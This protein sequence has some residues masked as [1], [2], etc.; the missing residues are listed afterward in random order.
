MAKRLACPGGPKWNE[1]VN[2]PDIGLYEAMK[3]YMDHDG[4]VRSVDEVLESIRMA[5][6]GMRDSKIV[7]YK[8]KA[9]DPVVDNLDKIRKWESDKSISQDTLWNKI[10]QLGIPKDQLELLKDAKGEKIEDKL[11]SFMIDY[12][13]QIKVSDTNSSQYGPT[14][15]RVRMRLI[16]PGGINYTSY[17]I[18][19]P[20]IEPI[21]EGHATFSTK[22]GIGWFRVDD[23][24]SNEK[25]R[26][27]LEIQ[28]DL[29]Q[30]SKDL[31]KRDILV[32]TLTNVSNKRLLKLLNLENDGT[33]TKDE[34]EELKKLQT[35]N[36]EN[37]KTEN[38]FLKILDNDNRWLTFFVKSIIQDSAKKGYDKVVFPTGKT[39]AKIEKHTLEDKTE[40]IESRKD[41]IEENKKKIEEI[42]K[43]FEEFEK[44]ANPVFTKN[45]ISI[46]EFTPSE[47]AI[48]LTIEIKKLP[49]PG[50][51]PKSFS[52]K[53]T[54]KKRLF[55]NEKTF[56]IN[57]HRLVSGS[58][59]AE[60]LDKLGDWE[61]F[62]PETGEDYS[63]FDRTVEMGPSD[64][65]LFLL[66]LSDGTVVL[67]DNPLVKTKRSDKPA[68]DG[69]YYDVV[70]KDAPYYTGRFEK[71]LA[72]KITERFEAEYDDVSEQVYEGGENVESTVMRLD[73]E[74]E[75][76]QREIDGALSQVVQGGENVVSNYPKVFNF[77]EKTVR[78]IL[79]KQYGKQNVQQITDEYGNTW[80]EVSVDTARDL[81]EIE[82]YRPT[83]L[84]DQGRIETYERT[85]DYVAGSENDSNVIGRAAVTKLAE[86][87]SD[88]LGVSYGMITAEEA[89]EMTANADVRWTNEPAFFMDDKV[90]F[91]G[92]NLTLEMAFHE[93]SH[94]FVKGLI[95]RNKDLFDKLYSDLSSTPEGQAIQ[96]DVI[97][98]YPNLE[99][100]S[101]RFKEEVMV[102]SLEKHAAATYRNDAMSSGFMK[103]IKDIM[104][105]IKQFLR[106][107]FGKVDVAKLSTNTTLQDLAEM[108]AKGQRF[109][110]PT[111]KLTEKGLVDYQRYQIEEFQDLWT[112]LAEGEDGTTLTELATL[113][114]Q[115]TI[116]S[117]R[118]MKESNDYEG[119]FNVLKDELGINSFEE[120]KKNLS[121]YTDVM[122][123]RMSEIIDELQ[124]TENH[125]EALIN[126]F[127]RLSTTMP[128]IT[129]HLESLIKEPNDPKNLKKAFDYG[130]IL[131]YWETFIDA[132]N[133]RFDE[134]KLRTTAPLGK[135]VSAIGQE[136]KR[137]QQKVGILN[138]E[139]VKDVITGIMRPISDRAG[140]LFRSAIATYDR[141]GASQGTR[142]RAFIEYHG[143][144]ESEY[145]EFQGLKESGKTH[146]SRYEQL[147]DKSFQYGA[148]IT[149]EKVQMLLS[150]QIKD[151]G[152]MNSWFEGYLYNDDPLVGGFSLF[153]K[154][155]LDEVDAKTQMK[156]NDMGTELVPLLEKIGYNPNKVSW[157]GD[158]ILFKD[159]IATYDADKKIVQ[160]EVWTMLNPFKDYRWYQTE[161]EHNVRQA[162]SEWIRTNSESDKK[163][164]QDLVEQKIQH[165]LDY[166]NNEF[167]DEFYQ[168]RRDFTKNGTNKIAVEALSRRDLLFEELR[169]LQEQAQD[170]GELFNINEQLE[171]IWNKVRMLESIYDVNGKLKTN[172]IK[173]KEGVV[174][175][176]DLAVA[177]ALTEYKEKTRKFYRWEKIKGSF[178][179]AL[180]KFEMQLRNKGIK[181]DAYDLA[182][183]A[184]IEANTRVVIKPEFFQE[185]KRIL[186]EIKG[187]LN[188]DG[189]SKEVN[190]KINKL[191]SFIN[192]SL[193]GFR[194]DDGQPNGSTISEGRAKMIRDA[195]RE[196]D[197]LRKKVK[198][199]D[200]L[201][202][203]R[204]SKLWQEY[205]ELSSN[206]PTDYY[207]DQLNNWLGKI[208]S[209]EI[210][211][212]FGDY[213]LDKSQAQDLISSTEKYNK[214]LKQILVRE[215][216][217]A[218]WFENNHLKREKS[219]G[220][221]EMPTIYY[222]R[223]YLWNVTV[224]TDP[225]Y[226][227][228]HTILDSNGKEVET[229]NRVPKIRFYRRVVKDEYR[230]GYNPDTKQ[231]ELKVGEHIDN[232]GHWLPK[233]NG[234]DDRYI[235][236]DYFDLKDKDPDVFKV[237]ETIKKYHLESQE[238]VGNYAKLYY[239]LPRYEQERLEIIQGEKVRDKEKE[240]GI[241]QKTIKNIREFFSGTA[242]DS[243]E[244]Q[245]MNW[246][247][248]YI[249]AKVELMD[250]GSVKEYQAPVGGLYDLEIDRVSKNVLGSV[251]RYM[252]STEKARK[253]NEIHPVAQA[254][255]TMVQQSEK[256][257]NRGAEMFKN[258][259]RV[260]HTHNGQMAYKNQDL[261]RN[262]RQIVEGFIDREFHGVELSPNSAFSSQAWQNIANGMF[263][264]SSLGYFAFNI[265]SSIKNSYGQRIQNFMEGAAMMHYNL[266][267]LGVGRVWSYNMMR[268]LS[269]DIYSN[270]ARTKDVQLAEIFD[271]SG[272][273]VQKAR[274]QGMSRTFLT[275]LINNPSG[276][277]MNYRKWNE[278][279]AS[280][281]VLGA[282]LNATKV[283]YGDGTISLL[284][285]WE[286]VDGRIQLKKGI[287]PEWGITYDEEGNQKIGSKFIQRKNEIQAVLRNNAG[288]YD[289]F[290]QPFAG[291]Y[292]AYRAVAFLRKYF[293]NMAMDRLGTKI[294]KIDG[295][296]YSL[297]RTQ[298]G[299]G[300]TYEGYYWTFMR[301]MKEI[302]MTGGKK[303]AFMLPA[304][305]RA[306]IKTITD[307]VR[308]YIV[309]MLVSLLFGWDPQDEER[310]AKLRAKSGPL[311]LP[312]VEE[313][314]NPFNTSG[315]LSN[316][317]LNLALQIQSESQQF[318]PL[319][320]YGLNDYIK[321]AEEL[322]ASALFGP[323]ITT[324]GAL[325][326]DMV[327]LGIG[328]KY[329]YYQRTVG[330][331]E[332]QQEGGMKFINH[333]LKPIGITGTFAEPIYGLKSFESAEKGKY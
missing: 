50:Q 268:Q 164:W 251:I 68:K 220:P 9:I 215:D 234:K 153:V 143:L 195:E 189:S 186:E 296:I 43:N 210:K 84:L 289:R 136:I 271:I 184:W 292:M 89:R 300:A 303:F 72:K 117:L 213:V 317:A 97:A 57:F 304:E 267:D 35:S 107:M 235:N 256:G 121:K 270:E 297:G 308:G 148:E 14:D 310:F 166:M 96:A 221:D 32:N 243:A 259:I 103:F 203:R 179:N 119:M 83:S 263:Q 104:Y 214:V 63:Y 281:E 67:A 29:F 54:I 156:M 40:F 190:E 185:R 253:L 301:L 224:P 192:Q 329:A 1:L 261:M 108:L 319:P 321:M 155:A 76:L 7:S 230:T 129:K 188:K 161:M 324:A 42:N 202:S 138:G 90:Y 39:I 126:T 322:D 127:F 65:K 331:Y 200:K 285:A 69:K 137:G 93:F 128:K 6:E 276:I 109:S 279:Q 316:H 229:I 201:L 228:S 291:R 239:D 112:A 284:D 180:A 269:M 16:V 111:E 278:M 169:K 24:E 106:G 274:K 212:L 12:G 165:D 223:S 62:D 20:E 10:Q 22:N 59:Y 75:E 183:Q 204:L 288:A 258:I 139:G 257:G 226:Y 290:N 145:R 252:F 244:T 197:S 132:V 52:K 198:I 60:A 211:K 150:G 80:N 94:P 237:L 36:L 299:L 172:E 170:E 255:R 149:D 13:Y 11:V 105:K 2:H 64:P 208:K 167:I 178:D 122:Q 302:V 262:R 45:D 320:G 218:E 27:I 307:L 159:I 18:S 173:T 44:Y 95:S 277:S 81:S 323:T 56:S 152:V 174:V 254:F 78:D 113:G 86:N 8:L 282:M 23:S 260:N 328:N 33:L 92:E 142:D 17:E 77:Y 28:S 176:N 48:N 25:V 266:K 286:V 140:E 162:Y 73:I 209:K 249:V 47:T 330:P 38:S 5:E 98:L 31:K 46:S 51:D 34:R 248:E 19:I 182:R 3:D 187:I 171:T 123:R 318:I 151:V 280:N 332:W 272:S 246:S 71:V 100:N 311:P 177:E 326:S 26:R 79:N 168:V 199:K 102:R 74:N 293:T 222:K 146:T 196:I 206:E 99:V 305:R 265:P 312:F 191:Y 53:E 133:Q 147:R 160:K 131:T 309:N 216:D 327:L 141:Y 283:P 236:K 295:K 163:K 154:N 15:K 225:E 114:Y 110:I 144:T 275:D 88:Q 194:D 82:F 91:V 115:A 241:W 134:N 193:S 217:F 264:I 37:F 116:K 240:M 287:D 125:V 55:F 158:R 298:V 118:A 135:L 30:K 242:K 273:F 205:D 333:L 250:H 231:V 85:A 66:Q 181:D 294:K 313:Q 101:D 227:E 175:T 233:M 58:A 157:L 247:D 306:A 314:D 61:G 325:M 21:L 49:E 41:V 124:Y 130:R 70:E 120:I 232:N 238:G 219:N 4:E 245:G 315:W 87:L 207:M